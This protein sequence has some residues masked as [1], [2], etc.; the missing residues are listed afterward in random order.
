MEIVCPLSYRDFPWRWRDVLMGY[1]P[2]LLAPAILVPLRQVLLNAPSW[3]WI[4]FSYATG[5]WMFAYPVYVV[6]KRTGLPEWPRPRMMIH[7]AL[8]AIPLVVISYLIAVA[9]TSGLNGLL[10]DS[11]R[12]DSPIDAMLHVTSRLQWIFLYIL[13][14]VVAPLGEE[15]FHRGMLYNALRQRM[16]WG[17]AAVLVSVVFALF[18]PYGLADRAA[19]FVL[20]LFLAGFYE[21]KKTLFAPMVLHALINSLAMTAAFFMAAAF[22]NSPMIGLAIEGR[23]E[24][25]LVVHVIPGGPAEKAGIKVG[26]IVREMDVYSVR[27]LRDIFS[28]MQMHKAGDTIPVKYLR[29]GK[30]F[31]VDVTLKERPK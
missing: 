20:G 15:P 6:R 17:P 5:M 30:Q 28:I 4:A 29:D 23:D 19:V 1:L 13:G 2:F 3:T 18:H 26:D 14:V 16:H 11:A 21:W 12:G 22:A 9:V 7:Q 10:G 8:L 27:D 31:N 25:C 24:G